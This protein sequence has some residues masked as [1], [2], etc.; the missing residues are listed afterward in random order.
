[1][2]RKACNSIEEVSYRFSRLLVKFQ[3]HM[4]QKNV[5]WPT[6]SVSGL[7]LQFEFIDGYEM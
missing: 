2:M 3:G 4:G 6:L 5:F 1:M 7:Y